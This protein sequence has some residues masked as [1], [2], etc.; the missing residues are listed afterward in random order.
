MKKLNKFFA[1][2]VALAMMATLCVSMA[3]AADKADGEGEKSEPATANL[4][5][6]LELG[7]SVTNPN[8]G[9]QFNFAAESNT[10][11]VAV[12][13][14][15][16][17]D[18]TIIV[19]ATETQN[20]K[21]GKSV[22]GYKDFATIL[23]NKFANA[24]AGVYTYTVSETQNKLFDAEGNE[25]TAPNEYTFDWDSQT[26]TIRVYVDANSTVTYVT[27][28]KTGEDGK[29]IITTK[30]PVTEENNELK[31]VGLTFDNKATKSENVTPD[32]SKKIY[33]VLNVAKTVE[34]LTGAQLTD[35]Q[36]ADEFKFTITL[37]KAYGADDTVPAA[38]I[39]DAN[40]D[41]D[42]VPE[43]AMKYGTPI[44]VTLKT[45]EVFYFPTLPAGTTW[46]V[47]EDLS[48]SPAKHAQYQ[49]GYVVTSKSLAATESETAAAGESL[50]TNSYALEQDTTG[51][52][53]DYTNKYDD[54]L[55]NPE[56]ILISNLPYIALALVAIG[57]LVAYVVVRRRQSDEA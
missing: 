52:V 27:A 34:N 39:H 22:Y 46:T 57:G 21:D 19:P 12:E 26:F 43:T 9:F 28:T 31:I 1:V 2:L 30:D 10:A 13:D 5:K 48:A 4:V 16:A 17:I 37:T 23:G 33:G 47:N 53:A 44:P 11:N 54:N 51:E 6:Y 24:K 42:F 8:V 32:P 49:P 7:D 20:N 38:K 18:S 45:G 56:G 25:V 40:G 50:A 35:A 14:M 36:K 29:Q 55:D 41:H 3:F 15:P